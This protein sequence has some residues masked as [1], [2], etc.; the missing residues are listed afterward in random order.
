[1]DYKVKTIRTDDG[2]EYQV[3]N[4]GGEPVGW[5]WHNSTGWHFS[6]EGQGEKTRREALDAL[7]SSLEPN[8]LLGLAKGE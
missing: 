7:I 5:L 3:Q 8:I 2:V 4:E 1:M 6:A